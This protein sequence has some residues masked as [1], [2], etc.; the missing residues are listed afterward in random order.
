[1]MRY[2]LRYALVSQDVL[3][4]LALTLQEIQF[5]VAQT[6]HFLILFRII[7]VTWGAS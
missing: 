3:E 5:D 2:K 1:M 7:N 4:L 6:R